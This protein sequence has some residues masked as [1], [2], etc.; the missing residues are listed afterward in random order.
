MRKVETKKARR[1]VITDQT[2]TWIRMVQ[3]KLESFSGD[4]SERSQGHYDGLVDA[5]S[6][7]MQ[8]TVA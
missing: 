1:P 4:D 6:M 2:E 3:D 7:M 8:A 5:L